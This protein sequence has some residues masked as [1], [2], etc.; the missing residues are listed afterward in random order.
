MCKFTFSMSECAEAALYAYATESVA[1]GGLSLRGVRAA[2]QRAF[3]PLVRLH[4][5]IAYVLESD[6]LTVVRVVARAAIRYRLPTRFVRGLALAVGGVPGCFLLT[7]NGELLSFA[8]AQFT[9]VR[10]T[11]YRFLCDG[12]DGVAYAA[13]DSCVEALDRAQTW[14]VAGGSAEA[15]DFGASSTHFFF[16][17]RNSVLALFEIGNTRRRAVYK[18]DID[19][20]GA[21]VK[22]VGGSRL[23]VIAGTKLCLVDP[24]ES[25]RYTVISACNVKDAFGDEQ[26]VYV[27]RTADGVDVL[28][29][30][31]YSL[32]NVLGSRVIGGDDGFSYVVESPLRL[33]AFKEG[34][35][36]LVLFINNSILDTK[37]VSSVWNEFKYDFGVEYQE[38]VVRF[39]ENDVQ[40]S[41]EMLNNLNINQFI[42]FAKIPEKSD[43]KKTERQTFFSK[44]PF[45]D[46]IN[47]IF[48][49]CFV[50]SVLFRKFPINNNSIIYKSRINELVSIYLPV[51]NLIQLPIF[52]NLKLVSEDEDSHPFRLNVYYF[53]H[54]DDFYKDLSLKLQPNDFIRTASI[55][56]KHISPFGYLHLCFSYLNV[57]D[58]ISFGN[59]FGRATWDHVDRS[60][61]KEIIN[62]L[63]DNSEIDTC[64]SFITN[65]P[66]DP[67]FDYFSSLM[68]CYIFS[69]RYDLAVSHLLKP[70]HSKAFPPKYDRI[71]T[72]FVNNCDSPSSLFSSDIHSLL[73][74]NGKSALSA[75]ITGN[76]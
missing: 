55:F 7:V 42:A 9:V 61:I 43:I 58:F 14:R 46:Y 73:H 3:P 35:Y 20:A 45:V 34:V 1:V 18:L 13:S 37:S 26:Y 72:D 69:N 22:V 76:K 24:R 57:F 63:I 50:L 49:K 29:T 6:A 56:N 64:I 48:Q 30:Y 74:Q 67:Q 15:V 17:Y 5:D 60:K 59:N 2:Q 41:E 38:N 71:F 54:S 52:K 62:L 65:L 10:R 28:E 36:K 47:S 12:S 33:L 51:Y 25:D 23:L 8:D 75:L 32:V 16:L 68:K 40:I 44:H 53:I 21:R 66:G 4:R 70:L 27:V 11:K 31:N 19:V 39:L